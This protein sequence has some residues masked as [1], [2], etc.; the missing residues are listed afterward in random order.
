MPLKLLSAE[1]SEADL[2][3]LEIYFDPK[4]GNPYTGDSPEEDGAEAMKIYLAPLPSST[5]NRIRDEIYSFTAEG[6]SVLRAGLAAERKIEN[7]VKK[8]ENVVDSDGSSITPSLKALR[9]L[10]PWVQ[11]RILEKINAINIL[12]EDQEL[13]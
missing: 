7:A 12:T 4:T 10:P 2:V 3:L 6:T 9:R 1:P 8:W 11:R 5:V 13:G